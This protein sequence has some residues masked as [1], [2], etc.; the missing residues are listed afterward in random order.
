[1]K[2]AH[3]VVTV[4]GAIEARSGD[5]GGRARLSDG[6]GA[7]TVR[8]GALH[9]SFVIEGNVE[10]V[11]CEISAAGL[12]TSALLAKLYLVDDFH[13]RDFAAVA[14]SDGDPAGA[15]RFSALAC[16]RYTSGHAG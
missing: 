2:R 5:H 8:N 7:G 3:A 12:G 11:S 13:C 15:A 9:V 16:Q 4:E 10:R 1:M 14:K 6:D